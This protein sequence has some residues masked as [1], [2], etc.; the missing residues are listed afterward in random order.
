MPAGVNFIK[1][2]QAHK[3]LNLA[4]Y[5]TAIGLINQVYL[6]RKELKEFRGSVVYDIDRVRQNMY[7]EMSYMYLQGCHYGT[8]YPPEYRYS[9]SGFNVN[10]TVNYCHNEREG[11]WETYIMD[12]ISKVGKK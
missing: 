10:S 1:K 7:E 2:I 3:L 5:L 8:D 6:F 11:K 12:R 4:I 9:S